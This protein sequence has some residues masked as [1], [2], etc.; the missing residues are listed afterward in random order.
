MRR[1]N[2]LRYQRIALVLSTVDERTARLVR[3]A[4]T[5]FHPQGMKEA[6]KLI[7]SHEGDD[8]L[9][10]KKWLQREKPDAI[11]ALFEHDFP[12]LEKL[13]A[14]APETSTIVSLNWSKRR[15]EIAGIDQHPARMGAQAVDLL[16][17][18]LHGNQMGLDALAPTIKIPGSWRNGPSVKRQALR[19]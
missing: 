15:P 3:S 13:R 5:S 2:H 11:V 4:F 7:F 10:S 12:R 6:E 14:A 19:S 17:L 1:L 16:L 9:V 18:R 8:F